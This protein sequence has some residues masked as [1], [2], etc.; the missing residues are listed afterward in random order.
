MGGHKGHA[1][2]DE[3]CVDGVA[4]RVGESVSALPQWSECVRECRWVLWVWVLGF[5]FW[6]LGFGFWVLGF[7]FWVLGFGFWVLE[8]RVLRQPEVVQT[9]RW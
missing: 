7:G 4:T 3:E 6:V 9:C 5:G 2:V 8:C 1:T